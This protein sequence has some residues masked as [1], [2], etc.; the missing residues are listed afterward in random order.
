MDK[1]SREL[2]V[3]REYVYHYVEYLEQAGL[4]TNLYRDARGSAL[5]RKPGKIF[6]ENPS[7]LTAAAGQVRTRAET[8]TMRETFFACQVGP[9]MELRL[10]E[11]ADFLVDGQ[12][13]IEVGGRSKNA[14]EYGIPDLIAAL[15]DI[16][17]GAGQRIPLYLFGF[18]Y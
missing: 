8:G 14:E 13:V 11:K 18:L 12:Y 6:M 4:I 3:S 9:V 5:V 10:H 2:A 1:L 16:E 7:I 15:D 17:I